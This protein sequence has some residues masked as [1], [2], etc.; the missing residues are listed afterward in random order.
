MGA[1]LDAVRLSVSLERSLEAAADSAAARAAS[2]R[3]IERAM[4]SP[5]ATINTTAPAMAHKP[6]KVTLNPDDCVGMAV[7]TAVA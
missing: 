6:M 7:G 4:P 2:L 1:N 3:R 5:M